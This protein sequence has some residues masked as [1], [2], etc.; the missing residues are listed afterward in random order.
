MSQNFPNPFNPSTSFKINLLGAGV[1]DVK[2]YDISGKQIHGEILTT[3]GSEL[4]YN[5]NGGEMASGVYFF[6]F[7]SNNNVIVKKQF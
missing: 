2:I 6:K 1:C 3:D 5:F 7:S 4:V